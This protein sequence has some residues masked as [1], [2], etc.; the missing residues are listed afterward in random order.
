LVFN[1]RQCRSVGDDCIASS[2]DVS[3][4][5]FWCL[6]FIFCRV[7][8]GLEL[9][10]DSV[11]RSPLSFFRCLL[12]FN[13]LES[14]LVLSMF[15]FSDFSR[16]VTLRRVL[17]FWPC[18]NFMFLVAFAMEAAACKR[19]QTPGLSTSPPTSRLY[20]R[21]ANQCKSHQTITFKSTLYPLDTSS[22]WCPYLRHQ[23]NIQRHS[24]QPNGTWS[25]DHSSI[26]PKK[27]KRY[28][29]QSSANRAWT[30]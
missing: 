24:G 16:L 8:W 5:V 25:Y 27:L 20:N 21:S 23:K 1:R 22:Q 11:V 14:S 15:F 17:A 9:A 18:W 28:T 7:C 26:P 13:L 29:F 2:F 3:I 19:T 10:V 6:M 30:P 4:F 12:G